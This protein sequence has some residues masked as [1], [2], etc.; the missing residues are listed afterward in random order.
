MKEVDRGRCTSF[1][2]IGL[3]NHYAVLTPPRRSTSG[4]KQQNRRLTFNI[5]SHDKDEHEIRV[6]IPAKLIFKAI[7]VSEPQLQPQGRAQ[8]QIEVINVDSSALA[9][10]SSFLSS[11]NPSTVIIPHQLFS[12]PLA[13]ITVPIKTAAS[14]GASGQGNQLAKSKIEADA[15]AARE[16]AASAAAGRGAAATSG[17][18][19]AN[20]AADV[21]SADGN[22]V[23]EFKSRFFLLARRPVNSA[24]SSRR[25]APESRRDATPSSGSERVQAADAVSASSSSLISVGP[26][27]ACVAD[28]SWDY[29]S[30]ICAVLIGSRLNILQL[31]ERRAETGGAGIGANSSGTG[32]NSSSADGFAFVQ[33]KTL[34]SVDISAFGIP[35]SMPS[36][37][38]TSLWWS[39]GQLF[40]VTDT[41][42]L[43]VCTAYPY[44]GKQSAGAP[45]SASASRGT[46]RSQTLSL[47]DA[48]IKNS[49]IVNVISIAVR[50]Q[51][52]VVDVGRFD[53]SEGGF[54]SSVPGGNVPVHATLQRQSSGRKDGSEIIN[55]DF[56]A[57]QMLVDSLT[58]YRIASR[59]EGYLEV[60][61][62]SNGYLLLST[63]GGHVHSL[64]LFEC[65]LAAVG[66][67]LSA[68]PTRVTDVCSWIEALP[69]VAQ[70][71][72]TEMLLQRCASLVF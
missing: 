26:Y 60:L 8:Q 65:P 47:T 17:S 27:M 40:V 67:L 68:G 35:S 18:K 39:L 19:S 32:R 72:A 3:D 43:L 57:A 37:R 48:A 16:Q 24:G 14:S 2:W 41:A 61:G 15:E 71:E 66:V 36:V 5:F 52:V 28:V 64:P 29:V 31:E 49:S 44:T 45:S 21:Q 30:G 4:A 34:G 69:S 23:Q 7:K 20:A 11:G 6:V 70:D 63:I 33:W 22:R 54:P 50:S 51:S 38:P 59:P 9:E 13:C 46:Q 55:R 42:V 53:H 1:A 58:P 10:N 62:I 25:A 56:S 12:G